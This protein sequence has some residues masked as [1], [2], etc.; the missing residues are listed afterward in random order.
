MFLPT[1]FSSFMFQFIDF[2]TTVYFF[3][4]SV[5]YIAQKNYLYLVNII[6]YLMVIHMLTLKQISPGHTPYTMIL[7]EKKCTPT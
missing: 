3:C 5:M 1:F 6:F 2:V 7:Y 4:D